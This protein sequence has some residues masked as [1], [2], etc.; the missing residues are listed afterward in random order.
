MG[1]EQEGPANDPCIFLSIW[2]GIFVG[3]M[4]TISLSC[5]YCTHK[6][7]PEKSSTGSPSPWYWT[8]HVIAGG[9]PGSFAIAVS[10][11]QHFASPKRYFSFPLEVPSRDR[12]HC[13]HG[14]SLES[15][16]PLSISLSSFPPSSFGPHWFS[17]IMEAIMQY[18]S[19]QWGASGSFCAAC[20]PSPERVVQS[21]SWIIPAFLVFFVYL[22]N[23]YSSFF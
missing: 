9:C 6:V 12:C 5:V 4:P 3:R 2:L 10:W 19:F 15:L 14:V 23:Q 1:Q 17:S 22:I 8:W 21:I 13:Q 7:G 18:F 20:M 11:E 16:P